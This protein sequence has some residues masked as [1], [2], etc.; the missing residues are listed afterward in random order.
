MT[1]AP[2]APEGTAADLL[3]AALHLFGRQ[4]FAATSTREIAARAGTNVAS[5][6]YH[7][8]SKE[9]LRTA[10]GAEVAR[11]IGT[12]IAAATSAT[13]G[14]AEQA[15]RQME[16]ILRAMV[17]FV[18]GAREA[19]DVIAFM[20]REVAEEGAVLDAVYGAMIEPMHRRFCAL[21]AAA[22][23]REAEGEATRL[24]VFSLVGQVLYF[25][26]GRPVVTRRMGW[27]RLGP[28][29]AARIG[30]LLAANL[31]SLIARERLP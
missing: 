9:G 29:E 15:A 1:D 11:R 13:P 21:W 23:G 8:G 22:T 25:R 2:K 4:G 27:E 14:S 20:L 7:F 6:A 19:E 16:A 3:A 24:M 28:A 18:A 10:C 17:G 5:I 30:D 31:H 26:I 12:V